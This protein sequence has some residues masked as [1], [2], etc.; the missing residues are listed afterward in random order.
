VDKD[1]FIAVVR[2][3]RNLIY[4]V[5]FTYCPN[6]DNRKDL[7]QE[8]LMQLWHSLPRFDGR[9]KL[10]TWLYRVALNTAIAFYRK[11][12]KHASKKANI[13]E[14]VFSLAHLEP[15][16]EHDEK[17]AMLYRYIEDLNE[18]DKALMLLYLDDNKYKCIADILGITETNVATK[19]NRIKKTLKEKFIHQ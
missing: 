9:V 15:N 7:E 8:I 11:D 3:H 1:Q 19:I 12:A 16:P 4:K 18:M 13:D 2:E 6:P 5:C 17:I 14:S 10:S